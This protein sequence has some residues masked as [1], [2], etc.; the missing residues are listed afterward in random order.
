MKKKYYPY[1]LVLP[2]FVV[3]MLF[4]AYPLFEVFRVSFTDTFLLRPTSGG[5]VGLKTY[6]KVLSDQDFQGVFFRTLLW[7]GIGTSF[8]MILGLAIGYFLSFDWTVNRLLRAVIIIPWII[9]PVV[10]SNT[11]SWMMHGQFGVFNDILMRLGFINEGIAFLGEP[12]I[13]LIALSQVLVWKNVPMVAILLSAAFQGIP[14][15]LTEAATI[16]GANGWQIF[17]KILFPAIKHTFVILIIM[18]SIWCMQQFVI[19]W[20]TTQGGPVNATHILPTYIY[21]VSFNNFRFG[22]GGVL[23]VINI[24]LL[25]TI[26]AVYLKVFK[27]DA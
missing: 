19:I 23:S 16:D 21:E 14:K 20:V 25:V 17:S 5:F 22:E 6:A 1:M 26:S 13:A 18:V 4:L 15:S 2:T 10:S 24:I 7:M 8:S 9:P 3:V 11:W 12:K 27:Q